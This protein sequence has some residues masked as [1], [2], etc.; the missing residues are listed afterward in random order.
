MLLQCLRL[1]RGCSVSYPCVS[2]MRDSSG[3]LVAILQYLLRVGSLSSGMQTRSVSQEHRIYVYVRKLFFFRPLLIQPILIEGGAFFLCFFQQERDWPFRCS[4]PDQ[5]TNVKSKSKSNA[6][7]KSKPDAKSKSNA[8]S[9]YPGGG[10]QGNDQKLLMAND[11][12]FSSNFGQIC[13][14]QK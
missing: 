2:K 11:Q 1:E 12:N 3:C 8:K 13:G 10:E 14:G 4:F 6:K 9:R 5:F 7:S